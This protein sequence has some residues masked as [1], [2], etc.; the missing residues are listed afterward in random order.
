MT[1]LLPDIPDTARYGVN[2]TA[3]ILGVDRRTVH[4]YSRK[5]LLK[6]GI[7]RTNGRKF[8]TGFE[9]KRAWKATA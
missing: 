2:E 3:E 1:N 4:A 9:I 7:R 8:F 6:Y 5:G